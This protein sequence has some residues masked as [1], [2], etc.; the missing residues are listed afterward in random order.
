MK[1]RIF[2][3][4]KSFRPSLLAAV[5]AAACTLLPPLAGAPAVAAPPRSPAADAA[6]QTEPEDPRRHE[7]V[8]TV[9][10]TRLP[11]SLAEVGSSVTVVTAEEIEA[12]GARWLSEVLEVVP[13]VGVVR[14]AGP[15][16][17]TSVFLR[18][19]NSNHTLVLVNGVKVNSPSTGGFDFGHLPAAQVERIEVVRGPQSSLY[20]SE[21]IG[22]VINI[23]TRRG[24]GPPSGGV[25]VDG[26]SFGTARLQAWGEGGRGGLSY[27]GSVSYSDI[28]GFSAASEARGA[29]EEDGY[30]NLSVDGRVGYGSGDGDGLEA[31]AFVRLIDATTEI[32]DF[33]FGVGPVDDDNAVTELRD[34]YVGGRLGLS[35]GPWTGTLTVSDT[36]RD[37]ESRNPDGVFFES[38]LDA[39]IR[40]VD[41]ENRV[42]LAAGNALVGGVE[43]RR[44]SAA[45]ASRSLFGTSSFDEEVD[46][47]GVYLHDRA[48]WSAVTVTAGARYEDHELFGGKT[49]FRVTGSVDAGGGLRLHGSAGSGFRAPSLNDLFFPFFGNP[50]LGPEESTGLDAGLE[51]RFATAGV[52]F[53]VTWF[54]NDIDELIVFSPL[55]FRAENI[56][57]ARSRGVELSG[58]WEPGARVRVRGEY[59]FTDAIEEETDEQLLRRPR[60]QGSVRIDLQ[61]HERLE[62]FSEILAKGERPD[63]GIAGRTTLDAYTVWNAAAELE[64][65]DRYS[66]VA[67]LD[68]LLDEDYEE[69]FGFGTAGRSAYA[70]VRLGFGSR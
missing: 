7:E 38:V 46:V 2:R 45:V 40:E 29:V 49:T 25:V 8:V 68:N 31:E 59:T 13:G 70:G 52:H 30:E 27:A 69:V 65:T 60:H 34:L 64:L 56:G 54:H 44:E 32:D 66:L 43:F 3:F 51:G 22:G 39:S 17:A 42:E 15:G 20:G 11:A 16:T 53:D 26:G 36:E 10:A 28:G 55:T 57:A 50:D 12:S 61:V 6:Q 35:R 41:F 23:V 67:R 18:G 21:A 9:T 5:L 24:S 63:F 1:P 14:T 19:A 62:L 58:G 47:V 33:L 48:S 4:D 37:L